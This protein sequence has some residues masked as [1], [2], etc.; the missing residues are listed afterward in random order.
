[1]EFD[2]SELSLVT[3]LQA[4]TAG[5]KLVLVPA[6]YLSRFQHPFLLYNSAKGTMTPKDLEGARVGSACSPPPPSRGCAGSWRR[7]RRGRQQD[8][9]RAWRS[10]TCPNGAI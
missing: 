7:L 5:R 1:M 4:K 9:W 8:Q 10:R 2:V 6:V 3:F